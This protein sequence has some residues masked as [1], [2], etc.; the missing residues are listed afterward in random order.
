[1]QG[2]DGELN[3]S[4]CNRAATGVFTKRHLPTKMASMMLMMLLSRRISRVSMKAGSRMT[5]SMR[6]DLMRRKIYSHRGGEGGTGRVG[7]RRA[8]G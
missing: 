4:E 1:M 3:G 2:E 6:Y 5:R 8:A 7:M